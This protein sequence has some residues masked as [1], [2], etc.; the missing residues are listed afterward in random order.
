MMITTRVSIL[1]APLALLSVTQLASQS[2]EPPP[3]VRSLVEAERAFSSTSVQDGIRSAFLQYLAEDAI[4]FRPSPVAGA[5]WFR[6]RGEV[7]GTLVWEPVFAAVSADG[8][9]GYTTGPWEFETEGENPTT[10]FGQYVSV[11]RRR[12]DGSWRVAVDAGVT[13]GEPVGRVAGAELEGHRLLPAVGA[14]R[15][16]VEKGRAELLEADKA[17]QQAIE[18]KGFEAGFASFAADGIRVLREGRQPG[19]GRKSAQELLSSLPTPT[20]RQPLAA[21]VS[22]SGDLGYTYGYEESTAGRASYFRIWGFEDGQWRVL[23]DV[24]TPHGA[25]G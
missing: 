7:A 21:E 16:D 11:W 22:P 10:S 9:L 14:E 18:T 3:A 19:V 15:S 1:A 20:E 6:E 2:S 12:A 13:H 24:T 23:V 5:A 25:D 8:A 4:I 17:Y